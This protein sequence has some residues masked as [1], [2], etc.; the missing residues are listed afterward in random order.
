[1]TPQLDRPRPQYVQIADFYRRLIHDGTLPEG[2]RLPSVIETAR[3]FDVST[4]T[5]ARALA[6]LQGEGLIH[7][8]PR[9]SRVAGEA[10]KGITPQSRI[11]KSRRNGLTSTP[12]E[13]HHVTA[14]GIVT[15]P[16]YIADYLDLDEPAACRREW[17]TSERGM[18]RILTV[19][20]YP[21]Q[22]AAQVPDLLSADP[23]KIGVMLGLVEQVTGAVARG[24]DWMHGRG[25]DMREATALQLPPST[26]ILALTW[27][28]WTAGG[29]LA[30]YGESCLTPRHTLSYPYPVTTGEDGSQ[31]VGA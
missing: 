2:S 5:A 22:L 29:R 25:A 23:E 20:W 21:P 11:M 18:P 27:M 31:G 7:S 13:S 10:A 1:M 14:A 12:A 8:S 24:R 6:A 15:A 16:P 28:F 26:P 9:G 19:T 3:E 17:V 30:E 4:A